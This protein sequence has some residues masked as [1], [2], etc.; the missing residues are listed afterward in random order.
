MGSGIDLAVAL[1]RGVVF[2]MSL[3]AAGAA[4]FA[5]LFAR[6]IGASAT[7]IR[8]L[9]LWSAGFA[10][11]LIIVRSALEPARMA[12]ALSGVFDPF[13]RSL[14]WESD[15]SAA[16]LARLGGATLILISIWFEGWISKA[17]AI[18][19]IVLVVLSFPLM[20]HTRSHDGNGILGALVA[21]HVFVGAF[22]FGAL[23]P[24][25]LCMRH[26]AGPELGELLGAFSR[27]AVRLV[28]MLLGA[29]LV[30]AWVLLGTVSA[31]FSVYS[32]LLLAKLTAVLVLLLL[33]A[34]NKHKLSP[35][36]AAGDAEAMLALRRSILAEIGI[37][38]LIFA[39]TAAMT[40]LYSPG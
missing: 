39:A 18:L 35:A 8:R 40:T 19:G 7:S 17:A 29:G 31:L 24:L 22:W 25:L 2:I 13:L 37:M 34:A 21:V 30:L 11:L 3:Q 28:P 14:F 20:G 4:L 12:G 32:L 15:V 5:L 23:V 26:G 16:Q 6:H 10:L 38:I 9:T 36:V 1:V 33:A 27:L